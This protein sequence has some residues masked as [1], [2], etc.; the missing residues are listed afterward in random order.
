MLISRAIYI[1]NENVNLKK[2]TPKQP[3]F[4]RPAYEHPSA[5][6]TIFSTERVAWGNTLLNEIFYKI[7]TVD[8]IL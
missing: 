2:D 5:L 1:E 7:C 6:A 4:S 8:V 3:K